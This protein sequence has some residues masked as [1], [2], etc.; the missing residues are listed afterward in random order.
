MPKRRG[1]AI[2]GRGGGGITVGG[3]LLLLLGGIFARSYGR[4]AIMATAAA[5]LAGRRSAFSSASLAARRPR[6]T[7]TAGASDRQL[8]FRRQRAVGRRSVAGIFNGGNSCEDAGNNDEGAPAVLRLPSG[9]EVVRTVAAP[10]VAA[11]DYP[12]RC[13]CRQHG[14]VDLV[15]TQMLHARNLIRDAKFR[16]NHLDLH[17]YDGDGGGSEEPLLDAQLNF[18]KGSNESDGRTKISDHMKPHASGPVVVQLAGNSVDLVVEAAGLILERTN[19]KVDGIDLNLGCPQGIARKGNYGAFLAETDEELACRILSG[20]R[21]SLPSSVAVSAKIRLPLDDD[22]L[23]R[24]IPRLVDTGIDFMTVHGR[25]IY[26]NKT[27]VGP[28]RVDRLRRA[29]EMA[30]RC[31]G[32]DFP[33]V[34]NGGIEFPSD[35]ALLRQ[36]TGAAAVMSSEALLE[37]PNLFIQQRGGGERQAHQTPR[38]TLQQ[39]VQFARDYLYWCRLYPPLPGVLGHVGG[40]CNMARGHLFKFLHRYI[41]EHPD[42]RDRLA[43]HQLTTLKQAEEFVD[44]LHGRY[45]K[46]SDDQLAGLESSDPGSSWYRRHWNASSRV[47]VRQRPAMEQNGCDSSAA[48]S[49]DERKR[50]A[51]NRIALLK[52]QRLAKKKQ[53]A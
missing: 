41:T 51:R 34:A 50:M 38:E 43:S 30:R 25:T 11:S 44:E 21:R 9:A 5:A 37:R 39:Q 33:V 53:E 46:L 7:T 4:T 32:P 47:H 23:E 27:R 20:L 49:V 3:L 1:G 2:G 12:F 48:I 14:N 6:R 24:R 52:K 22:G 15:F 8:F 45:E 10:M 13:L 28:C 26:D 42:L 19:G 31:R 18:L 36:Q 16:A 35:V 17:E 40:S 29:V